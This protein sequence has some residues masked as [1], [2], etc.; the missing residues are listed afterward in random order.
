M[1]NNNSPNFDFNRLASLEASNAGLQNAYNNLQ[2]SHTSVL[3][4]VNKFEQTVARLEH[5]TNA[6][7]A[8][9]KKAEKELQRAQIAEKVARQA[10]AQLRN[11]HVT[12]QDPMGSEEK[13][14]SSRKKQSEESQNAPVDALSDGYTQVEKDKRLEHLEKHI[15]L[16]EEQ[17]RKYQKRLEET[18]VDLEEKIEDLRDMQNEIDRS[19]KQIDDLHDQLE[20][21]SQKH[22]EI[23][24]AATRDTKVELA[25]AHADL[26][27]HKDQIQQLKQELQQKTTEASSAKDGIAK[28]E[29]DRSKMLH[30]AKELTEK[31]AYL[32]E[33]NNELLEDIKESNSQREAVF[34]ERD[35]LKSSL[36]EVEHALA[37]ISAAEA[38]NRDS[39]TLLE[40]EV[41]HTADLTH[42]DRVGLQKNIED[43]LAQMSELQKE[44]AAKNFTI[45]MK[46]KRIRELMQER[47]NKNADQ[48]TLTPRSSSFGIMSLEDELNAVDFE[49]DSESEVTDLQLSVVTDI[50]I[51]PVNGAAPDVSP[52]QGRSLSPPGLLYAIAVAA[53]FLHL[54]VSSKLQAWEGANGVGF[55][56]GYGGKFVYN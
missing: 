37:E 46:E 23:L 55:G 31:T 54:Q 44:V 36:A 27:T 1:T 9:R 32:A 49:Q 41:Q 40:K 28:A 43:V 18:R 11:T 33:L 4:K 20:C 56:E 14:H 15:G 25:T 38:A 2:N 5:E 3:N 19:H 7:R 45:T 53:L 50:S 24:D 30:E 26:K 21:S 51:A 47:D 39:Y 17:M 29:N 6:E 34:H 12:S 22:Q 42:E 35:E 16:V 52:D 13:G 48:A 8:A 10:L